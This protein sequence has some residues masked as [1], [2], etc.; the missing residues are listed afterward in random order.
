MSK[1]VSKIKTVEN[2]EACDCRWP[3]GDPRNADFRF[4]GQQQVLGRPYCSEH[5]AQA[6]EASKPRSPSSAP[7][8]PFFRRAA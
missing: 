5:M 2:L 3:I 8:L 1:K 7:M 6:I 4:C